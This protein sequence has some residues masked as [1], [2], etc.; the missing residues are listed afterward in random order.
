[1]RIKVEEDSGVKDEVTITISLYVPELEMILICP[2]HWIHGADDNF[3][4]PRS[5]R[6]YQQGSEFIMEWKQHTLLRSIPWDHHA[7]TY[8]FYT[9]PDTIQHRAYYDKFDKRNEMVRCET[10]C[11][12]TNIISD[13]ESDDDDRDWEGTLS[14]D[15][16][17]VDENKMTQ[18]GDEQNVVDIMYLTTLPLPEVLLDE[19]VDR[20]SAE[21]PQM[22][23]MSWHYH[24]GH[25]PFKRVKLLAQLGNLKKKVDHVNSPKSTGCMFGA[26]DR[27]PWSTKGKKGG[28][29]GHTTTQPGQIV[30]VDQLESRSV[31]SISQLKGRVT[32]R[33]YKAA[34]LFVDQYSKLG[35]VHLQSSLTSEGTGKAT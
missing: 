16:S 35:Y 19:D 17:V 22:E 18:R 28:G 20:L 21:D 5:T 1:M 14:G 13:D 27:K 3:P 12:D 34:T 11:Y 32:R 4:K 15:E 24:V 29:A 8:G 30:S 31:G 33:R 26:T 25:L 7:N 23:L 2:Q 6:S 10:V 9:A